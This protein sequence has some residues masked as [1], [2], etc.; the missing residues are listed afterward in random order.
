MVLTPRKRRSPGVK[1]R[2]MKQRQLRIAARRRQVV[3]GGNR[4]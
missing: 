1:K 3:L 4:R 2:H